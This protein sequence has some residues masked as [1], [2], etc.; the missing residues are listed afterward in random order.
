MGWLRWIVFSVAGV[1]MLLFLWA[2]AMGNVG[3][4][5]PVWFIVVGVGSWLVLAWLMWRQRHRWWLVL[6]TPLVWSVVVSV[7]ASMVCSYAGAGG[8]WVGC[9]P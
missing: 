7:M 4:S 2:F 8:V 3:V 6:L 9:I 5:P 1:L